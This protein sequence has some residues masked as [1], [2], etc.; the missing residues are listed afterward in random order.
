MTE[1]TFHHTPIFEAL[2]YR[3]MTAPD[4]LHLVLVLLSAN[5]WSV[6]DLRF[7]TVAKVSNCLLSTF[8]EELFQ[9]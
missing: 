1:R 3:L 9:S 8:K 2:V 4:L 5:I 7:T 6:D